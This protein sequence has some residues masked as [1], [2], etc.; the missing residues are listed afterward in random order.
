MKLMNNIF[1]AIMELAPGAE[2]SMTDDDYDTMIWH[3]PEI[4]KP[5]IEEVNAKLAELTNAEPMRRLRRERDRLLVQ[6]DWSQGDDVPVGIRSS[7]VTYRQQLRDLPSVSTP[8][9]GGTDRTGITS[10]TW[11]TKPS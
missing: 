9:L 5:T 7:Y 2:F 10:V 3:T 11:P 8:V 6:S 4:A 1:Y